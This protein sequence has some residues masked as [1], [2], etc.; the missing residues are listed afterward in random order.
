M[1][2][3]EWGEVLL[4]EIHAPYKILVQEQ[5]VVD[6]GRWPSKLSYDTTLKLM[7]LDLFESGK[8]CRWHENKGFL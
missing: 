7:T 1:Q 8:M 4:A 3:R 6:T 5:E 2:F